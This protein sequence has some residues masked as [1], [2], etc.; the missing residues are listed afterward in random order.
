MWIPGRFQGTR[1]QEKALS[2]GLRGEERNQETRMPK[3]DVHR[4]SCPNSKEVIFNLKCY[5]SPSVRGG[6]RK[7]STV[8]TQNIHLLPPDF[9]TGC[10]LAKSGCNQG[11]GRNG[12]RNK[13]STE[14]LTADISG[15]CGP[16]PLTPGP[17]GHYLP[18]AL[19]H[20]A[21]GSQDPW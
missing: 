5:A 12:F 13:T 21:C 15:V 9:T 10:A 4:V 6:G 2:F 7:P 3:L 1:D 18:S 19:E 16:G 14:I 20:P 17:R 11:R 8:K